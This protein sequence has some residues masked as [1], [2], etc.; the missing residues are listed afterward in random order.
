MCANFSHK[1]N[2]GMSEAIDSFLRTKNF[3]HARVE[4]GRLASTK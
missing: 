2:K 4:R 1:R 3:K